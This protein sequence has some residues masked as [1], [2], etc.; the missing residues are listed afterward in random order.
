ML[1]APAFNYIWVCHGGALPY[2]YI[3]TYTQ[4]QVCTTS[5]KVI[6]QSHHPLVKL[7]YQ[8]EHAHNYYETDAWQHTKKTQRF[9]T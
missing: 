2:T 5:H 1:D 6:A 3:V 4:V 9:P 7:S 8:K